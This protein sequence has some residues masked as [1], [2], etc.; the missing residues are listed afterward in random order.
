MARCC[1][2][3]D[4]RCTPASQKSSKAN[5][6]K[7][8]RANQNCL[9]VT[10]PRPDRSRRP[11]AY[12][13]RRDSGRWHAQRWSKPPSSSRGRLPRSRPCPRT[14]ALRR[15]QIKLQVALITPLMHVKGPTAAETK[16]AAERARLLVEQAEA[17]GEPPDDPLILFSA[18]YGFWNAVPF[19]GDVCRGLAAQFLALAA[20]QQTTAPRLIGHRMMGHTLFHT[21]EF[22]EAKAHFDEGLALYNA[23]EHRPLAGLAPLSV[24]RA[25]PFDDAPPII[26][27]DVR[28]RRC[29]R[30]QLAPGIGACGSALRVPPLH[31]FGLI[32]TVA[33]VKA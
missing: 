3:R 14:P 20:K 18:L 26:G 19:N 27:A 8:P 1:G 24:L 5:S 4:A 29:T 23:A 32:S 30:L 11:R 15:E 12:G 10:A 33:S 22:V 28:S 7:S 13:A 2:S 6:R 16:A 31:H 9:R 21:G 25:T 17:L